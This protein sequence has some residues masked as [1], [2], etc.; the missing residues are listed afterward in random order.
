VADYSS[1]VREWARDT[2]IADAPD[3]RII[4][5]SALPF[6]GLNNGHYLTLDPR[7]D[8]SDPPVVY[9]C[10][11]DESLRLAQN[12]P[13][14]PTAWERPCYLRPESWLL[15]PFTDDV[16]RLDAESERAAGLR[17]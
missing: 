1:A 15:R 16:G 7:G 10:H 2:W 12:L 17:A 9:L 14:F 4:W 6:V 3:Q 8:T 13:E 11:D 5:E